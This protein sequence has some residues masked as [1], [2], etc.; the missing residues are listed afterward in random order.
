MRKVKQHYT[1]L[2]TLSVQDDMIPQS[3]I[4][5]HLQRE[6]ITNIPGVM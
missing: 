3:N 6:V 2:A 4:Y 1:A 5:P